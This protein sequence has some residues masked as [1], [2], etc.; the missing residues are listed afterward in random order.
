MS[1]FQA[2]WQKA[3]K[4]FSLRELMHTHERKKGWGQRREIKYYISET[5]I[6]AGHNPCGSSYFI[7]VWEKLTSIV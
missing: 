5:D 2:N 3:S 4:C 7:K 6:L 1:L